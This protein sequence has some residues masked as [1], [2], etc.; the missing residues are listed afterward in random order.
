MKKFYITTAIDYA[1]GKPHI[2]HAYEKILADVISRIHRLMGEEVHFLTGLDEH[3][4]KVQQTAEKN[5]M[6]PQE[7]CNATAVEFRSMCRELS[8]LYDDYVRTT[9]PRHKAV[10]I[11]ILQK[12][13]DQGDIYKAEYSGYYST[14]TEQF[15][16]EKDKVNGIWP[17]EV[18][19]DVIEMS[20]SNYFFRLTKHRDW[21]ADYIN[22]HPDFIFPQ[23]RAK[24]VLEFLADDINDLCISRP[25]HRLSWGIPL[26][27]DDQ[28][29]T[30]VWFDAL[31]NYISVVGYG[32]NDFEEYWP[33]DYHTIGKD[34]LV[35]AHAVYWPIML[36]ALDIPMPK[37]LLAHGWWTC[38]GTKMSKSLGNVINPMEY[39]KIY[40]SDPVRYF[41]IREMKVGQDSDFSHDL[42]SA[43]YDNDLG[44]DLGN[45]VSR[46][47]NMVSRYCNGV[48]PEYTQDQGYD[49]GMIA[50]WA[51]IKDR[52][53]DQCYG[54]Q[55]HLAL[56]DLFIFIRATNKYIETMAP[57]K[58]AKSSS[59]DDKNTLFATLAIAAECVRITALALYPLM[60]NM[61]DKIFY[62]FGMHPGKLCWK[63][64][65]LFSNSLAGNRFI[66]SA[67]LF[68]RLDP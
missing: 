37:T 44:N 10:V 40:G 66:E 65:L 29:V 17:K 36:H 47:L 16:Q 7:L 27:F 30:Y 49:G 33:V 26:P 58:L 41:L 9:Q 67:I 48:C 43:R 15:L 23:F 24:Q 12:L 20:E 39:A 52:F 19:G 60:P 18:F 56:D 11:N 61:A 25:K 2:G 63:T 42:F 50:L 32:T 8:I 5:G 28:Y 14:V 13:F 54:L 3:G 53:I 1:N 45:L 51:T 62:L 34:I 31:I 22:G 55:F 57:W 21:L 46:I 64:D 6:T 35:P 4:Q 59:S 38:S 68:P